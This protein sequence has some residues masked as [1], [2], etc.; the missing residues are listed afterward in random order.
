MQLRFVGRSGA[1][2]YYWRRV[3]TMEV[4]YYVIGAG[5]PMPVAGASARATQ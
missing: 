1:C 2:R 4:Y 3:G 5:V